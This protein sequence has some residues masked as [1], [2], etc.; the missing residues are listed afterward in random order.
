MKTKYEQH[1]QDFSDKAHEAAQRLVYP[2][3]LGCRFSDIAFSSSS[4]RDGGTGA[5]LDGEMAIDRSVELTDKRFRTQL[6]L[7]FQ[8]RFRRPKYSGYKDITVTEW[9]HASD[10]PSELYKMN[11]QVFLY[12]YYHE[13]SGRFSDVIAIDVAAFLLAIASGSLKWHRNINHKKQQFISV[14]FDDLHEAGVVLTHLSR[15]E[16]YAAVASVG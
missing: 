5:F 12:G 1:N 8:E 15:A 7:T 4:V 3:V 2:K 6:K 9:N 14:T 13:T 11:C 16:E 10:Q